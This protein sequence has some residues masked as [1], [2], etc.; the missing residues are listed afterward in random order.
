MVNI[1]YIPMCCWL[2]PVFLRTYSRN[3]YNEMYLQLNPILIFNSIYIYIYTCIYIYM[4]YIYIHVYIYIYIHILYTY[5]YIYIYRH[6]H[7]LFLVWN[8]HVKNPT[9]SPSGGQATAAP[10][11]AWSM[12]A[13]EAV[14]SLA[15]EVP[16]TD[17]VLSQRGENH[18]KTWGNLPKI[19]RSG[20]GRFTIDWH[21]NEKMVIPTESWCSIDYEIWWLIHER[22]VLQVISWLFDED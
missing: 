15:Q 5:T 7:V 6:T 17:D 4:Y 21:W 10:A 14:L 19:W 12:A 11:A 2:N 20:R 18:R 9:R 22:W 3:E 1:A 16:G 13:W 8:P